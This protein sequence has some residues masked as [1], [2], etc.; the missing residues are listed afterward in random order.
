LRQKRRGRRFSNHRRRRRR[1]RRS[2]SDFLKTALGSE[3]QQQ[4][5]FIL[6]N[7]VAEVNEALYGTL[8]VA[9]LR[10]KEVWPEIFKS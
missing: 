3:L 9:S 7:Y 2:S 8:T 5:P 10:K 6:W 4:L 1:R